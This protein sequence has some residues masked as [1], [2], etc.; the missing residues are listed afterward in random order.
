MPRDY[1]IQFDMPYTELEEL[2]FFRRRL[3]NGADA[4]HKPF[5]AGSHV[6]LEP[7]TGTLFL[8]PLQTDPDFYYGTECDEFRLG[9]TSFYYAT[10]PLGQRNLWQDYP[11]KP[12]G[13][14]NVISSRSQIAPSGSLDALILAAEA[15]VEAISGQIWSPVLM[16]KATYP[17]NQ[18]F[19][20]QLEVFNPPSPATKHL[21][22]MKFGDFFLAVSTLGYADLFWK[23]LGSYQHMW[24]Y[25]GLPKVRQ[26]A[27]ALTQT[28]FSGPVIKFLI[29][30][31][32]RKHIFLAVHTQQ[33]GWHGEVY[34]HKYAV[35]SEA[36]DRYEITEAGQFGIYLANSQL[37][38]IGVQ[39]SKIGYREAGVWS[40]N[41]QLPYSPTMTH[42]LSPFWL[43][44]FGAPEITADLMTSDGLG[45][46]VANGARTCRP[47][48]ILSGD[49]TCTPWVDGYHLK[50]PE[51]YRN[52]APGQ[53]DLPAANL[54]RIA[55]SDG[56]DLDDQRCS[57]TLHTDAE[58]DEKVQGLIDRPRVDGQLVVDGVRRGI[59]RFDSPKTVLRPYPR[60]SEIEMTGKS[61]FASRLAAKRFFFPPSYNG[62]THPDVVN[63]LLQLSGFPASEITVQAED[64]KLP[65]TTSETGGDATEAES[66]TQPAFNSP[67][68]AFLDYVIENYSGWPLRVDCPNLK[69]QYQAVEFPTA[70]EVSFYRLT[71]CVGQ[72]RPTADGAWYEPQV[73]KE[74]IPPEANI[75]WLFGQTDDGEAIANYFVD[76]DSIQYAGDPKPSNYMGGMVPVIII[77]L[78]LNTQEVLDRVLT[79]I[80]D[81]ISRSVAVYSWKGPYVP[82]LTPYMGVE[83]SGL[84]EVLM[85]ES[86]TTEAGSPRQLENYAST[87]YVAKRYLE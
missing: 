25:G 37:Q 59:W 17:I 40:E 5:D 82:E 46:W 43:K 85:L 11:A 52:Y 83:L 69:W 19:C 2:G 86:I 48:L 75:I 35:W 49:G 27:L 39:V 15:V 72:R 30:P 36:D 45:P 31:M 42:T 67:V 71:D 50:F 47:R 28:I 41:V 68:Q 34:T 62:W 3:F 1:K 87:T 81:N 80:G 38:N 23:G 13:A 78:M 32:G 24:Q 10:D 61:L 60:K 21:I 57:L 66:R 4:K 76:W 20:V 73:S 44:T 51:K 74:I 65:L 16:S 14:G 58:D 54:Q 64:V 9:L 8:Q 63:N 77:D 79:K 33:S 12:A 6:W 53:W 55:I 7:S 70:A 18:G 84:T 29:I 22:G 26:E 56:V